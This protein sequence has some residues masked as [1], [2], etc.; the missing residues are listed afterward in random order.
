MNANH[1]I[2]DRVNLHY[3]SAAGYSSL[4]FIDANAREN[5][6]F[7]GHRALQ[8]SPESLPEGWSCIAASDDNHSRA[9]QIKLI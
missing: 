2:L 9:R 5:E 1:I 7:L 6:T 4:M 8:H 3:A